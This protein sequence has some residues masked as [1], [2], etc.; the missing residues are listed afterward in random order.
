MACRLDGR[1]RPSTTVAFVPPTSVTKAKATTKEL[2]SN[3]EV[4]CQQNGH[5]A[6]PMSEFGKVLG[7]KQFQKRKIG[8]LSAWAGL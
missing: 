5:E 7:R 4:W 1:V 6:M 8:G 3:F 2:Y